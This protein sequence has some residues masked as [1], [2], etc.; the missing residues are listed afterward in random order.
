[1]HNFVLLRYSN[2]HLFDKLDEQ[3]HQLL[4]FL[5]EYQ[6]HTLLKQ[7]FVNSKT[8]FRV[9]AHSGYFIKNDGVTFL[10]LVDELLKRGCKVIYESMYEVHVSGHACQEELKIIQAL[11]KPK[12]FMPVHGEYRHLYAN[13][14]IAEFMGIPSKNIFVSDIGRVLEIDK[15]GAKLEGTVPAGKVLVDG[16]GVG[17]V[18]SVVLRDRRHLAQDGIIVVVA[19]INSDIKELLSGPEIISRGFVYVKESEELME[20]LRIKTEE[21]LNFCFDN[22]IEEFNAIKGKVKD[23]LTNYIYS[24]TKRKPMILPIIMEI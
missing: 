7:F 18:G 13:K 19:T 3:T 9:S 4:L 1:M 17:D 11:T 8:F 20:G 2:F 12:Y 14:E 6:F 16:L 24:I 10:N 23:G 15:K 22:N 5:Q 21:I